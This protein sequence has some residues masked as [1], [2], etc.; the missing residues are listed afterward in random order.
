MTRSLRDLASEH[1]RGTEGSVLISKLGH[2]RTEGGVD[3]PWIRVQNVDAVS[4]AVL[5][6]FADT[7]A[8]LCETIGLAKDL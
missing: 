6:A 5:V 2:Y 3:L 7:E 4:G 8:N 1:L